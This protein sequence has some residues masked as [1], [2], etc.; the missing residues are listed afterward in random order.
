MTD[1]PM[2][3]HNSPPSEFDEIKNTITDL[4]GEAKNW[5]DGEPVTT[6]EQHDEVAKLIA[7]I[8]EAMK[9][10]E[11][12]R[13]GEVKPLDDQKAE[14]QAKFNKLIGNTK[15]ITG[16]AV[17]ALDACKDIL[18]PYLQ[19]QQRIKDDAAKALAEEAAKAEQEALEQL[20]SREVGNLEDTTQAE[21]AVNEAKNIATQAK[22]ALKTATTKT[23]MR[24]TKRAEIVDLNA[25]VK[26]YWPLRKEQFQ[27]LVQSFADQ[28]ARSGINNI[29]GVTIHSDVRAK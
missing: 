10:A 24:T 9:E 2:K 17:Q 11:K 22:K 27:E 12:I 4:F 8:K 3:G 13:K 15:S 21:L 20:R 25:A 14:I 5:C 18:T 28:D 26:Y 1:H 23:G 19:E 29:P 7:S 6:K 16:I